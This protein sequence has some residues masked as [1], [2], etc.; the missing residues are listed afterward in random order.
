[1][2][3]FQE[4]YPRNL[5]SVGL[6]IENI[7]VMIDNPD[8][9]GCGEVLVRGPNI[10]LG[11]TDPELTE[12]VMRDEWFCTGDIGRID[13]SGELSLTGRIKRVI[14]TEAGKNVYP[15]ELET[16][17]ERSEGVKEAA[18]FELDQ[19]PAAVLAMDEE[20]KVQGR[21]VIQNFNR[22]ASSHNQIARFA[23]V[24]DLPKTPLGKPALTKLPEVFEKNEN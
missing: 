13:A 18:V 17:L 24:A 20:N 15:E 2:V 5:D 11:Y 21:S 12:Q 22:R 10:M 8:S 19:R 23:V 9:Q 4:D 1:M 3:C 14:V 6:P 16:L 7:E